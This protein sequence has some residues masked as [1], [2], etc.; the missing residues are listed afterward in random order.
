M[1]K[2]VQTKRRLGPNQQ[3][4]LDNINKQMVEYFDGHLVSSRL[5]KLFL[6][7]LVQ[8]GWSGLHGPLLKAA[9]TRHVV[10]FAELLA[11]KYFD[12]PGDAYHKAIRKMVGSLNGI[13]DILYSGGIFLTDLEKS[14]LAERA[15]R[16]GFY[17]M[18]CR[19]FARQRHGMHFAYKPKSHFAQHMPCQSRLINPRYTQCYIEE[20]LVGKC[21]KLFRACAHGKYHAKA[22][23]KACLRY[24]VFLAIQLEF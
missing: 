22:Q 18:L 10:P 14:D 5:P 1:R 19:Q 8:K 3:A 7:N 16:L 4:R 2:L 17:Q 11:A 21:T 20:S 15:Q 23:T 12:T 13:Y 24:L 6:S 9:N